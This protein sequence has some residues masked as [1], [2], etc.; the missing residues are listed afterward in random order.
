MR[1]LIR[2]AVIYFALAL[3]C[4]IGADYVANPIWHDAL[5][6]IGGV[7]LGGIAVMVVLIDM[8]SKTEKDEATISIGDETMPR[9]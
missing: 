7:C 9:K 3:G 8:R 6:V 1:K 4:I 2:D 5:L